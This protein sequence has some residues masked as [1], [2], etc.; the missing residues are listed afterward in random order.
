MWIREARTRDTAMKIKTALA[1]AALLTWG[2]I[3]L[4]NTVTNTASIT[5]IG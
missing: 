2:A 3:E 1:L 5:W 4:L